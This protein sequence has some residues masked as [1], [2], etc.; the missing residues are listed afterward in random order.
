MNQEKSS[1][2]QTQLES[3]LCVRQQVGAQ[4]ALRDIL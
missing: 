3:S 2:L 4:I 1:Q